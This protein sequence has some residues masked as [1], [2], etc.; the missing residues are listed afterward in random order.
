MTV[1]LKTCLTKIGRDF[2]V[3]VVAPC[4]R[5]WAKSWRRRSTHCKFVTCGKV[6]KFPLTH[7]PDHHSAAFYSI[8]IGEILVCPAY[9]IPTAL[10][11]PVSCLSKRASRGTFDHMTLYTSKY[12]RMLYSFSTVIAATDYLL[13]Q[14]L[15]AA[16]T[17]EVPR[18]S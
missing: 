15:T 7:S 8:S 9:S 17:R 18:L 13:F 2:Q 14:S 12:F 4:R 1:Y 11:F 10:F 3:F 5:L 16:V 6:S